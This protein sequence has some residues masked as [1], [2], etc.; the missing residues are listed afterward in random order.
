MLHLQIQAENMN[1]LKSKA[2]LALG[3][4]EPAQS[5]LPFAVQGKAMPE[6]DAMIA[7]GPKPKAARTKK[8]KVDTQAAELPSDESSPVGAEPSEPVAVQAIDPTP[9]HAQCK[10]A[11]AK[12]I[13]KHGMDKAI[14][15][16]Q[17]FGVA[18]VPLLL[19]K[20]LYAFYL[21]CEKELA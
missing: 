16:I 20:D 3:I 1:E 14:S 9:T 19:E 18:K 15:L 6:H 13:A 5:V 2:F 10:E 21:A 8:E 4:T 7:Q 12:V 17:P 11:L